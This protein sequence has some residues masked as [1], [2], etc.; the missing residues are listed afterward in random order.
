M[1]KSLTVINDV[2][3]QGSEEFSKVR[4]GLL[5]AGDRM[6]WLKRLMLEHAMW[7]R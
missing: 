6:P 5:R 3:S 2:F 4:C 7:L 1:R